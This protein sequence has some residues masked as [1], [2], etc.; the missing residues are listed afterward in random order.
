MFSGYTPCETSLILLSCISLYGVAP[1]SCVFENY[2]DKIRTGKREKLFHEAVFQIGNK[3]D[4]N[5][6]GEYGKL[7]KQI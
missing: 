4:M 7:A 6:R 1:L 5:I 3:D 2:Y